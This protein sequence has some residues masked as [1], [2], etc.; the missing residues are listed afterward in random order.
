MVIQLSLDLPPD[1]RGSVFVKGHGDREECTL[2][3]HFKNKAQED[4]YISGE[5][6][7][8]GKTVKHVHR[9][10]SMWSDKNAIGG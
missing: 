1:F 6:S 5:S 10:Q 4:V 7:P 3:P 9:Q 8:S 2:V